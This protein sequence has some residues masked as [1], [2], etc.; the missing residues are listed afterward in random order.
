MRMAHIVIH[1]ILLRLHFCLCLKRVLFAI[2]T[3]DRQGGPVFTVF[4]LV[5]SV[6]APVAGDAFSAVADSCAINS[7]SVD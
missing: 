3:I 2:R 4:V 6:S 7:V 5:L 1:K